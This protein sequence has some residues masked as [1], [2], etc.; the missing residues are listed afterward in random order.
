MLGHPLDLDPEVRK[1]LLAAS[2]A[3]LDR[4][5]KPV[6][7]T[8]ASRLNADAICSAVAM[9]RCVPLLTEIGPYWVFWRLTWWST[10][11]R[12]HGR[13]FRL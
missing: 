1:R 11:G 9:F 5:L 4:L 3:T 13:F 10:A 7:A 2:A 8:V 6:H 12:E